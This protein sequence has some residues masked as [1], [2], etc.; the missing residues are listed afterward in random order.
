MRIKDRL[1]KLLATENV[2]VRHSS[3]AKTASF[4]IKDRVLTL[5]VLKDM[6]VDVQDILLSDMDVAKGSAPPPGKE[7]YRLG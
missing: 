6:D 4:D 5:P 7:K 1:A 3:T 2:T